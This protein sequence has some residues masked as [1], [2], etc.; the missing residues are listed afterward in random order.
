[1]LIELEDIQNDKRDIEKNIQKLIYDFEKKYR[2]LVV[3]D[4]SISRTNLIESSLI[5]WVSL[6]INLR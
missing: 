3:T 1:M 2:Q 4:F 5:S 6:T